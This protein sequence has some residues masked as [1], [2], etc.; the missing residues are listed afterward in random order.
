M[1][2]EKMTVDDDFSMLSTDFLVLSPTSAIRVGVAPLSSIVFLFDFFTKWLICVL[3][4]MA[5]LLKKLPSHS[6]NYILYIFIYVIY[7]NIAISFLAIC[8]PIFSLVWACWLLL[9][10]VYLFKCFFSDQLV[11]RMA[12]CRFCCSKIQ[13][14]PVRRAPHR[15]CRTSWQYW[16]RC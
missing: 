14:R 12:N 11:L 8:H 6:I 4:L 5:R 10:F 2:F 13:F 15:P 3:I 9:L 1:M 16:W 7:F